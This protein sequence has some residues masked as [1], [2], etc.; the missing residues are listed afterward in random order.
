MASKPEGARLTLLGVGAMNSPRYAPAGLLVEYGRHRV[1]LD[2]GPG[3]EP[4]GRV[5]A[6]L[7]TDES[8][9]LMREIRSLSRA[10]GVEPHVG[11]Y[12]VPGLRIAPRPVTHTSHPTFGYSIEVE[13]TKIVWAPEF[14]VFPRWA[15]RAR[16]MFAEAA[17]YERPIRFARG[18]GGHA[19]MLDVARDAHESGVQTLVFAHIGRPS[20]RALARGMRPSFGLPGEDGDIFAVRRIEGAALVTV[21]R[22]GK[23]TSSRLPCEPRRRRCASFA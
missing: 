13:R 10:F 12:T 6:W 23:R 3:A 15:R 11:G 18:A 4:I 2:G 8:C 19:S 9:E 14:L 20:L 22:R 5:D 21:R 1:M 16:L 7:L 17:G